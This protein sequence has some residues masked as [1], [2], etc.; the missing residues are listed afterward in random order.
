MPDSGVNMDID[1][2]E[3]APPHSYVVLAYVVGPTGKLLPG[4]VLILSASSAKLA[5]GACRL[6]MRLKFTPGYQQGVAVTTGHV[7]NFTFSNGPE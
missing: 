1:A 2:S 7:E 6:I 4:S 5:T 3:P